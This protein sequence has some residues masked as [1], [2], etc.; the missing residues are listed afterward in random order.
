MA[1]NF[2]RRKEQRKR[3]QI[4]Y[5]KNSSFRDYIRQV[6]S[7][8]YSQSSIAENAASVVDSLVFD[9]FHKVA[10]EA[11]DLIFITGKRTMTEWDIQCA[12]FRCL[13]GEVAAHAISEGRKAVASFTDMSRLS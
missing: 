4:K 7:R 10:A 3:Q 9:V 11:K 5:I 13:K 12:V 8:V 1:S 2:Q 6:L